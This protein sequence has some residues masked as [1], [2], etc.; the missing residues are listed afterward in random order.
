MKRLHCPVK[1]RL[2]AF[3]VLV[4]FTAVSCPQVSLSETASLPPESSP[5]PK[6]RYPVPV[7]LEEGKSPITPAR[8]YL[9]E[10]YEP[11]EADTGKTAFAF[12]GKGELEAFLAAAEE[13]GDDT[14][15]RFLDGSNGMAAA[16]YF[17]GEEPF[18]ARFTVVSEE[19]ST[20]VHGV[21]S[22]YDDETETFA[23]VLHCGEETS[24]PLTGFTLNKNAFDIYEDDLE[25]SAGENARIRNYVTAMSVW[26]AMTSQFQT[27]METGEYESAL[28]GIL[29]SGT[30]CFFAG[31]A[32]EAVGRGV[33]KAV[34]N[35]CAI[36]V[37]IEA[38]TYA[39]SN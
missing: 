12:K 10:N 39:P 2:A 16:M 5:E 3:A 19:D 30:G 20:A 31:G 7:A 24:G 14:V 4:S 1:F 15:A 28:S 34:D 22:P 9:D 38:A 11:A 17:T 36:G 29:S 33:K 6:A 35:I 13:T 8:F 21:F 25:L 27:A 18:P 37:K 23:L 32:V 26:T